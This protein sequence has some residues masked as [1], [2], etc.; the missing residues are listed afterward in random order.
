MVRL[1]M[2]MLSGDS[3]PGPL[4]FVPTDD[5]ALLAWWHYDDL[6][7]NGVVINVANPWPVRAGLQ[8]GLNLISLGGNTV[9]V[10]DPSP[11]EALPAAFWAGA[12]SRPLAFDAVW[13]AGNF[14]DW[15]IWIV[16]RPTQSSSTRIFDGPGT[17]PG[18]LTSIPGGG[19]LASIR[20][21]GAG[22]GNLDSAATVDGTQ[23]QAWVMTRDYT[24][25]LRKAM[26]YPQD[27]VGVSD[28]LLNAQNQFLNGIGWQFMRLNGWFG[29]VSEIIIT[30]DPSV[31]NQDNYK[32]YLG[33]TYAGFPTFP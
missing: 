33:N 1:P 17:S 25:P 16:C 15:M 27:S 6:P 2:K 20:L 11:F 26:I 5:T 3:G 19:V 18:R 7:A 14:A 8:L 22:E 23:T 9:V 31:A 21:G 24:A 30:A 13:S 32:T 28:A 12:P 29:Y 4:P 10:S